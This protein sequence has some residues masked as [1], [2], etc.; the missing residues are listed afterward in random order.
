[1]TTAVATAVISG[2]GNPLGPYLDESR[3]GGAESVRKG[4]ISWLPFSIRKPI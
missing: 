4:E 3:S 2:A 1:M